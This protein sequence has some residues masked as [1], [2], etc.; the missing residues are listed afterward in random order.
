MP[1]IRGRYYINPIAGAAIEKAREADDASAGDDDESNSD[2][3]NAAAPVR[4]I[5]IDATEIVP[6]T[7]GRAQRGFVARVHRGDA[8][9]GMPPAKDAET[10]VFT[11][12]RDLLGYLGG[13]LEKA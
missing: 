10:R 4:R 8:G 3:V 2:S 9:A 11:D 13:E 6:P 5:E 7:T 12:H 1:F